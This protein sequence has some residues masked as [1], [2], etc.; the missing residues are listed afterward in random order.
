MQAKL[1]SNGRMFTPRIN[2]SRKNKVNLSLLKYGA[3]VACYM[4]FD[5]FPVNI[6]KVSWIEIN[7][8]KFKVGESVLLCPLK[9]TVNTAFGKLVNIL[10]VDTRYLFVC[11]MYRIKHFDEH[12]Q[13]FCL[14]ERR[15]HFHLVLSPNELIDFRVYSLHVPGYVKPKV[16]TNMLFPRQIY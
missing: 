12:I 7:S 10:C 1:S 6:S 8:T 15:D 13:A 9:G 11:K 4:G 5:S 16:V 14:N 3:Q 2:T